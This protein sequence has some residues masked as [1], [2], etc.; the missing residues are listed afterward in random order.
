MRSDNNEIIYSG[1]SGLFK[2]SFSANR[3]T[4]GKVERSFALFKDYGTLS[5][6]SLSA[7]CSSFMNLNDTDRRLVEFLDL[8]LFNRLVFLFL[9]I[10]CVGL[11]GS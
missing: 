2:S 6:L 7:L 10:L 8:D 4:H 11:A 5:C 9:M 3:F 1:S